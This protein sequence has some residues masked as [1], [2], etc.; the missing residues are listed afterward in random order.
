[1]IEN[2]KVRL[3]LLLAAILVVAGVI[4][5]IE[6]SG[7]RSHVPAAPSDL[8]ASE[9]SL[10]GAADFSGATGWLNTP[11]NASLDLVGLRG[12]VVLVDFW[13]YS[14]INCIHTLPHVTALYDRY[15][16]HGLVVVGVHTP[17]FAFEKRRDNV[18]HAI[19]QYGIH[20]PVPQD[21]DDGIWNAY[22]NQ[23][24]PADYL[25]DQYGKV[26]GTHFGEGGYGKT[27]DEVRGLL[28]EAGF[29]DLPAKVE[30]LPDVQ[31]GDH[32]PELYAAAGRSAIGNSEGY[33][34]GEDVQYSFPTAPA[35]D[36]IYLD[37]LW[38]DHDEEATAAHDGD[39]V[40]V[41]FRGAA[42]NLVAAGP[43]GACVEVLLDGRPI[44]A[45]L[46]AHDVSVGKSRSCLYLAGSR[47]YDLYAGPREGHTLELRVPVGFQLYTFDFT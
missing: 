28:G 30:P 41:D 32:S 37:G 13:T 6:A 36:K 3:P 14:C 17:E 9:A 46:A 25:V 26:R 29:A 40:E 1:M 8:P 11:N 45:N 47:S 23:Y 27:E 21:N 5:A 38:S 4:A 22:H 19:A 7:N 42:A 31:G 34:P 10:P 20:Y 16:D 43:D 15:R 12:K 44:P 33:R 24:W 35:R 2:P 18:A 39:G